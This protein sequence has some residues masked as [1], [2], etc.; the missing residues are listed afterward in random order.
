R[1]ARRRDDRGRREHRR[2]GRGGG[3]RPAPRPG[4]ILR[5]AH[6]APRGATADGEAT[7]RGSP[8]RVMTVRRQA[9]GPRILVIT[10]L[11]GSGK[12][13]VSRALEDVGWFCVDNLPTALMPP[14]VELLRRSPA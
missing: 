5:E 2:G 14:F 1:G 7:A 4:P 13:H 10:G 11:S 6:R 8:P 12:T 9:G 3:Q